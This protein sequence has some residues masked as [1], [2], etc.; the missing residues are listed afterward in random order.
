MFHLMLFDRHIIFK[1][2]E[3]N[4]LVD[5]TLC[6]VSLSKLPRGKKS[7]ETHSAGLILTAICFIRGQYLNPNFPL[8]VLC[9][10]DTMPSFKSIGLY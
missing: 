1:K 4:I 2:T 8:H 3:I 7:N 9:M 6:F 5:Y 10:F